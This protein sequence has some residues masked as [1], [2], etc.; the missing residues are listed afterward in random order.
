MDCAP[1]DGPCIPLVQRSF[2]I[3]QCWATCLNSKLGC[4]PQVGLPTDRSQYIHRVGRTARAGKQVTA[5]FS[6]M[7]LSVL[8]LSVQGFSR[9]CEAGG[10][11]QVVMIVNFSET[12]S[13][14]EIDLWI[15]RDGTEHAMSY[16]HEIYLRDTSRRHT[17]SNWHCQ[18]LVFR[19][20]HCRHVWATCAT[21]WARCVANRSCCHVQEYQPLPH[22]RTE[23]I[24][25]IHNDRLW[26]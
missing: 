16:V 11:Q 18:L 13:T 19:W 20:P 4:A 6:F 2:W 26:A 25:I 24:G 17:L 10:T 12:K 5:L 9:R 14:L 8:D 21:V 3:D 7:P 23:A 22:S 15:H 1:S